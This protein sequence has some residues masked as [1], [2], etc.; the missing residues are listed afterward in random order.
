MAV[1]VC[2]HVRV[3]GVVVGDMVGNEARKARARSYS[4]DLECQA[5]P[6]T[7]RP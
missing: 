2:A 3:F 4:E 1:C 6:C 5:G 7:E